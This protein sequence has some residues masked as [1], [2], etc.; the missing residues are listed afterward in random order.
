MKK[1]SEE[2]VA[3]LMEQYPAVKMLHLYTVRKGAEPAIV[4]VRVQRADPSLM[5]R[6]ADNVE[7]DGHYVCRD[8][9]QSGTRREYAYAVSDNGRLWRRLSWS[10]FDK[11]YVKDLFNESVRFDRVGYIIWVTHYDW[12]E[13]V[14]KKDEDRGV[15]HGAHIEWEA[16]YVIYLPPDEGFEHLYHRADVTKNVELTEKS[17]TSGLINKERPFELASERLAQLARWFE[18]EVF[19]MGELGLIIDKSKNK[20]MSGEFD[21]VSLRSFVMC[22]RL[23]MTFEAP[24]PDDPNLRDTFTIIG[25]EHATAPQFGWR[26]IAAT[27]DRAS[28]MVN[29]VIQAWKKIPAEKRKKFY[30]DNKNIG[31][32]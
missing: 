28:E 25:D 30:R 21:G 11:H 7:G 22:G 18:R 13:K 32:G 26:S 31:L 16:H 10:V 24:N 2:K 1:Q 14:G 20:G 27:A 9:G 23:M 5:Y 15:H 3:K 6:Q 29:K 8:G 17:L 4:T 12:Y 19:A